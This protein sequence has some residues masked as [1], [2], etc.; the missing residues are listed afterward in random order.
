MQ[1]MSKKNKQAKRKP[2]LVMPFTLLAILF[3]GIVAASIILKPGPA[4]PRKPR[5]HNLARE[6]DKLIIG[7]LR[8]EDWSYRNDL[9]ILLRD[10]TGMHFDYHPEHTEELRFTAL[11]RWEKWWNGVKTRYE[12]KELRRVD[13][14]LDALADEN[15]RWRHIIIPEIS[16]YKD[17]RAVDLLIAAM[18]FQVENSSRLRFVSAKALGEIGNASA[19]P[20]LLETAADKDEKVAVAAA[21]AIASIKPVDYVKQIVETS[22]RKELNLRARFELA[23][24][25]FTIKAADSESAF[26]AYCRDAAADRN[27]EFDLAQAVSAFAIIG[28][29]AC[30]DILKTLSVHPSKVVRDRAE[31]VRRKVKERLGRGT[32]K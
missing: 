28:T 19:T 1:A 10:A 7:L 13:W 23:L 25:A 16:E 17:P 27:A 18:K 15:Y 2:S 6:I 4:K 21:M 22:V 11:T 32:P 24:A 26:I 31:R 29:E 9:I 14:L 3:V 30:L 5:R 12:G 20:A 8:G